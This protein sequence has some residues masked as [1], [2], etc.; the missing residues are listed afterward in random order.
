M[1]AKIA[2]RNMNS[3]KEYLVIILFLSIKKKFKIMKLKTMFNLDKI[4]IYNI[5]FLKKV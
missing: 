5:L 4:L 2:F 1:F 3:L